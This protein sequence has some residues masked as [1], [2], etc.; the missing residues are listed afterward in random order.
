MTSVYA[1]FP[2]IHFPLAT[3]APILSADKA[4]HEMNSVADMAFSCFE[5]GNQMVRC[6]PREGKYMANC[7]L[8]R[9]DVVPKDTNVAIALIKTKRTIQFVD[10]CPTG[11]KL[12]ICNKPPA[13]IP[14]GDQG[15]ALTVHAFQH[16]RHLSSVESS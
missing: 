12:G 4:H 14:S 15:L 8:H 1:S 13:Y 2:R 6:D 3:Y 10:W 16:N 11:F 9:G 7:Q 5:H